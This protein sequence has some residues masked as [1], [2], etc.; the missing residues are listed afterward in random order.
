MVRPRSVIL[1]SIFLLYCISLINFTVISAEVLPNL[2][3]Q[4]PE[5]VNE[6]YLFSVIITSDELFIANATVMFNEETNVTD[7]NGVVI[8]TA[9]R[10]LPFENRTCNITVAK[11]GYNSTSRTINVTNVPQLYPTLETAIVEE[12]T[13]FTLIILD[14]EGRIIPNAT[15]SFNNQAYHTDTNGSVI[16][17]TPAVE[18]TIVYFIN[19]TKPGYIANSIG[20]RILPGPSIENVVGAYIAIAIVAI[21]ITTTAVLFLIRYYQ[22]WRFNR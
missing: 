21:L 8:F 6:S 9:P 15:V 16:L 12:K 14:D 18:T 17:K 2:I 1:I 19:I 11:K 5:D 10:V 20:I 7:K 13:N 22:R 3:I 4:C